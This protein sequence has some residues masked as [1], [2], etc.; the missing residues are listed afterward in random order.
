MRPRSSDPSLTPEASSSHI[1][2]DPVPGIKTGVELE[3]SEDAIDSRMLV[4]DLSYSLSHAGVAEPIVS[5]VS[6]CNSALLDATPFQWF[7]LL[8]QDAIIDIQRDNDQA[9]LATRWDFDETSLSRRASPLPDLTRDGRVRAR[10]NAFN[11]D[12]PGSDSMQVEDHRV[13]PETYSTPTNSVEPIWNSP[14][15][16]TIAGDD[17]LYM[18]HYIQHIGPMLD[19]F[20]PLRSFT[21]IVPHLALKNTGLLKSMLAVA[22]CHVSLEQAQDGSTC[23]DQQQTAFHIHSRAARQYYYETLRYLSQTLS[24]E[25][26]ADSHEILATAIMISTFEMLESNSPSNNDGWERHLKGSFWILRCQDNDGESVDG[27]RQAVW[28]AWLRQDMWAALGAGRP[29]LTVWYPRTHLD[30]LNPDQLC[31]RIVYIA[32]KVVEYAGVDLD[33]ANI[34]IQKRID[35]GKKLGQALADWNNILPS[36]F[37]P[38]SHGATPSATTAMNDVALHAD[39]S[40]VGTPG[41]SVLTSSTTTA[42]SMFT[43]IWIHP[44]SHAGAIQTFHFARIIFLLNIPTIGGPKAYQTRQQELEESVRTICGIASQLP[45]EMPLAFVNMQALYAGEKSSRSSYAY[46]AKADHPL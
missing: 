45:V 21:Q 34:N 32:A 43:P 25:S 13:H 38:I 5:P 29:T 19:L 37:S 26:Y 41:R 17:L 27:L 15:P 12:T 35:Q 39:V 18:R 30:Q 14:L 23:Q 22:A 28:W 7:D 2:P 40:D 1:E 33:S 6:H 44:P 3:F 11:G 24:T 31:T 8:A 4:A 46:L 20:D 36:S 9:T 10:Q 42:S 16:T